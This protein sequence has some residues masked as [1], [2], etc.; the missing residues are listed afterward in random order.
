VESDKSRFNWLTV[1]FPK[2]ILL[3][4]IVSY[5]L[6]AEV[7]ACCLT[8]PGTCYHD[9]H[10][11]KVDPYPCPEHCTAENMCPPGQ[12]WCPCRTH[13]CCGGHPEC[14]V[15]PS[16]C[17]ITVIPTSTTLCPIQITE[18]HCCPKDYEWDATY[19]CCLPDDI[20]VREVEMHGVRWFINST[21]HCANILYCQQKM[22]ETGIKCAYGEGPCGIDSDGND[23]GDCG[24]G[25]VC[26]SNFLI[27]DPHDTGCCLEHQQWNGRECLPH[28]P[29]FQSPWL[30]KWTRTAG[31][32]TPAGIIKQTGGGP[33]TVHVLAG[34][35]IP[36]N[37]EAAGWDAKPSWWGDST[38]QGDVRFEPVWSHN[39]YPECSPT[40]GGD[41]DDHCFYCEAAYPYRIPPSPI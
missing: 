38:Q 11:N 36:N 6:G 19:R 16:I 31:N 7:L 20:A 5:I 4:L 14:C 26:R 35:T 23:M 33:I 29:D 15:H 21:G 27:L 10:G 13:D 24:T 1:F 32:P 17:N 22:T 37:T 3:A 41:W 9:E 28:D 12:L 25:L 8:Y 30:A 2:L 18:N 40:L 34:A 39:R